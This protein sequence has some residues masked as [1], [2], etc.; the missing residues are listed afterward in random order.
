M[1]ETPWFEILLFFF[2][3]HKSKV[4]KSLQKIEG[5]KLNSRGK[6]LGVG[7][8]SFSQAS[9]VPEINGDQ[10]TLT[11][12]QKRPH[13][14]MISFWRRVFQNTLSVK[15]LHIYLVD[16]CRI[17]SCN[18]NLYDAYFCSR[19]INPAKFSKSNHSQ[20]LF[21][22]RRQCL[23]RHPGVLWVF[24]LASSHIEAPL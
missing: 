19:K 2:F 16:F 22:L 21:V 4:F 5:K 1:S 10:R 6:F 18:M 23:S 15:S 13:R 11:Y 14:M 20:E 9:I 3:F 12:F 7:R 8:D 17:K 24:I